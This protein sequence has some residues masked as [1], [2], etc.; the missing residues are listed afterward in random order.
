[1]GATSSNFNQ[2]TRV[3]FLRQNHSIEKLY[4]LL[5]SDL[6]A[7]QIGK[8]F[9]IFIEVILYLFFTAL[10]VMAVML[11]VEIST[12]VNLA[13]S[14]KLNIKYHNDYFTYCMVVFKAI[15]P[16]ASLPVFFFALVL[17]RARKRNDLMQEAFIEV[18]KMKQNF[19]GK[20]TD[21]NN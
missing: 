11:P 19:D 21:L 14:D 20:I 10:I 5:N 9:S 1:M 15:I 4:H 18:K 12:Y 6:F 16:L 7:Y 8:W 3:F 13:D 17:G 2:E